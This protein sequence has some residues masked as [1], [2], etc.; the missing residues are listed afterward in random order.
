M[1]CLSKTKAIASAQQSEY[2]LKGRT[3]HLI[4]PAN[5]FTVLSPTAVDNDIPSARRPNRCQPIHASVYSALDA[6]DEVYTSA[7]F[8]P[9]ECE[10]LR[11]LGD[12]ATGPNCK[13]R[14]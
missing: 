13:T 1:I 10:E 6:I 8:G 4:S 2:M 11:R 3:A 5:F 12:K 14:E 7:V 9:K